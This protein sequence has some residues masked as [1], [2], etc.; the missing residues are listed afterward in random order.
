MLTLYFS[1]GACSLASHI[2]LEE[3]GAPYEAKP[4]FLAKQQQRTAEYLKIN[5]RGKVPSLSV[6]GKTLVENTAIL[7]YLAKQFPDKKLMPSDPVEAARCISTMCWFS[8]IVHPSFQHA[9]RPERFAEGD[10]A[11]AAVKEMG[12]KNFWANLQEINSMFQGDWI[13]GNQ[14]TVVDPYALVF[15]GWAERGGFPVKDLSAYT[16]WRERMLQ[17]PTVRKV[18]EEEQKLAA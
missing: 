3:T 2:G 7:S 6:D 5:P 12:R 11:Q 4:V 1:P 10:A 14:F 17:R 9:M 16:A 13:M 18:V 8:S 15:Y